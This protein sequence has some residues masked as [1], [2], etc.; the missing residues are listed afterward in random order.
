MQYA[1]LELSNKERMISMKIKKLVSGL[2]ISSV[3]A[4]SAVCADAAGI[5]VYVDNSLERLT[6]ANGNTVEPFIQNGTTYVPLRGISQALGCEVEWDGK[7]KTVK[8]Y[9]DKASSNSVFHNNS[10]DIKVYLDDEEIELKDANGGT[11]KPFIIDGTTFIPL[12]GVSQALG[13]FVR[14]DGSAQRVS[15]YMDTVPPDGV[16]LSELKPYEGNVDTYYELDGAMAELDGDDYIN[17]MTGRGGWYENN[18]LFN[19]DGKY[20][21]MSFYVGHHDNADEDDSLTFIVDGKIVEKYD[22]SVNSEGE[23]ITIPLN[24][25]LQLKIIFSGWGIGMG[26]VTFH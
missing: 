3:I 21:S 17:A 15:V 19:L 2:L 24:H 10:D 11:V 20:N 1:I 14:W 12:R 16:T 22:L 8:I 7:N 26:N 6:D 25:G 18:V 9:Q 23:D 5:T 4:L 13:C